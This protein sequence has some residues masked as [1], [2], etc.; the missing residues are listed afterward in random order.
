M[1]CI[2]NQR[3]EH[4][5]LDYIVDLANLSESEGIPYFITT[6]LT[7][8]THG[9]INNL[10][11]LDLTLSDILLKLHRGGLL[12]NTLLLIMSDHGYRFDDVRVTTPGWYED[13]LP[14]MFIKLPKSVTNHFPQ[15]V[16]ALNFNSK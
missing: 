15:S 16:E 8:L 3:P 9:G 11:H 12:D 1:N 4:I 10:Q 5:I 2:G 7:D 6:W 13:K 14:A